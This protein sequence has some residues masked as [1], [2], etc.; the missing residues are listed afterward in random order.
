MVKVIPFRRKREGRT[1]YHKRLKL[2]KS[3]KPRL[4]LR[5]TNKNLIAQLIEFDHVGDKVIFGVTSKALSNFGWNFSKNNLPAAYLFG[6]YVGRLCKKHNA[7]D[8]VVDFGLRKFQQKGRVSAFLKGLADVGISTS[9][10][11]DVF[12]DAD[13]ISGKHIVDFAN[14]LKENNPELFNKQFSGYISQGVDVL[15]LSDVFEK[16]KSKIMESDI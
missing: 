12:P 11:E 15:K 9:H 6:L 8:F 2:L 5:V 3:G 4:V 13:R 7:T 10:D 16:A 1:D 14:T